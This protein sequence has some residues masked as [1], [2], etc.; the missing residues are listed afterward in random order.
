MG[1]PGMFR[2]GEWADG[3]KGGWRPASPRLPTGVHARDPRNLSEMHP[4]HGPGSRKSCGL[5]RAS[6]G[7]PS[8]HSLSV[9][10]VAG[11]P[12]L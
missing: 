5:D 10:T 3:G 11:G 12:N 7:H 8:W 2:A 4:G 6:A 9:C 1:S